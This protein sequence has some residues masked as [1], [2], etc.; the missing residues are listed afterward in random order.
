MKSA[1]GSGNPGW[2]YHQVVKHHPEVAEVSSAALGKRIPFA[3]S[4]GK[5]RFSPWASG[6]AVPGGSSAAASTQKLQITEQCSGRGVLP[7]QPWVTHREK[8]GAATLRLSLGLVLNWFRGAA[9]GE[10]L[11]V[12]QSVSRRGLLVISLGS[13]LCCA[14]SSSRMG[15]FWG[16]ENA[17]CKTHLGGHDLSD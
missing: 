8:V 12:G 5:R 17:L 13:R 10:M 7:T 11:L 6:E 14:H 1:D 4:P 2:F 9:A 15:V 3:R 16:W